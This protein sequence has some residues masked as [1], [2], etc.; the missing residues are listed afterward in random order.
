MS[1]DNLKSI[2]KMMSILDCFSTL[3]RKLSVAEIAKRTNMP[4]GTAH[5]IIRTMRD[6]GL[7]EQERQRDQYRLGMK[8]FELGT[9]VLAN[10]D[11][12]REAQSSVESLTRV[13]GE[14]VHL[15]V[16]DGI[17]STVI[18]RTDPEGKRVN[19]LFVLESSPA[20]ATSSGKVALAFQSQATLDRF[21]ALGLRRISPNTITDPR[22]LLE[23]L[24]TI[25]ANGYAVDNEELTP[26]TK[27]V[28]APIRS[29][30]GRVFAAISV[31]GPARRFAPERI[32]AFADLVKHYAEAISAQLG[33]RPH[34]QEEAEKVPPVATPKRPATRRNS[35]SPDA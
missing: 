16:F 4:R 6:L 25:R 31:S 29:A 26:G 28:G 20:H 27:C 19:T 8:L 15:S 23:E 5:R 3:E 11:L 10:M 9:T 12:Q 17:N 30:S 13:S 32:E 21:L 33:Y 22:V 7:M 1:Q 35:V 2:V 14:I 24:Q 18:N 34:E